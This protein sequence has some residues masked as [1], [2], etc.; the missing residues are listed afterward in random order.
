MAT[1]LPVSQRTREELT[2]LIEG[3]IYTSSAKDEAGDAVAAGCDWHL[4]VN[5]WSS[6]GRLK[7][8]A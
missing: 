7:L 1:R 4:N 6:N 5:Y 2:A 8:A 3:R